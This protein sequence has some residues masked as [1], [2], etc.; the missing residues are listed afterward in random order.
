MSGPSPALPSYYDG[1]LMALHSAIRGTTTS[2]RPGSFLEELESQTE[3]E[4]PI[5]YPPRAVSR[6]IVPTAIDP[7]RGFF[8]TIYTRS[9]PSRAMIRIHSLI[10]ESFLLP[11]E[12]LKYRNRLGRF[13]VIRPSLLAA[14]MTSGVSPF[15]L[16][17]RI[18]NWPLTRC[19]ANWNVSTPYP[20]LLLTPFLPREPRRELHS[21]GLRNA[22][23][24][25]CS[26]TTHIVAKTRPPTIL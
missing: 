22:P 16:C 17:S 26:C 23:S 18:S 12:T 7:H 15:T 3:P 10:R 2:T 8:H 19:R 5:V 24:R 9:A 6:E 4:L 21:L 14:V 25:L 13:L 20:N 1:P 11:T